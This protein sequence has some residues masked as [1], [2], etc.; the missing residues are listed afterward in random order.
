MSIAK[1]L[2]TLCEAEISILKKFGWKKSFHQ[3]TP[4]WKHDNLPGHEI[5]SR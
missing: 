5:Y 1:D 3:D 4:A 2:L